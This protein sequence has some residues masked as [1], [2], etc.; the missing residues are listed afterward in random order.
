MKL[1]IWKFIFLLTIALLTRVY[2]NQ[3]AILSGPYKAIKCG[4]KSKT[5]VHE[6]FIFDSKNGYLYYFDLDKNEFKPLSQRINK[7]IY[8]YSMEEHASRLEKN[9][10]IGNKLVIKYIDY[11]N[12]EPSKNSIIK[13]TIYLR[14]LRMHTVYQINEKRISTRVDK[15]I[16]VD[17]KEVN[18]S[19]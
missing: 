13:K 11:L 6:K 18:T 4:Q 15:C 2:P 17:P 8:F 12:K 10:L 3:K 5:S 16:W 9:K 1:Y 14:W 7:G 19:L